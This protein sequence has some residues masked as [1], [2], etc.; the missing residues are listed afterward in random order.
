[1]LVPRDSL[2][3][4]IMQHAE[5]LGTPATSAFRGARDV[6]WYVQHFIARLSEPGDR[7]AALPVLKDLCARIW[8]LDDT[9]GLAALPESLV[10]GLLKAVAQAK[11]WE[12]LEECSSH[13]GGN[14]PEDFFE[15]ASEE[16]ATGRMHMPDVE[17]RYA[18]RTSRS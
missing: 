15:W 4:F 17:K 13:L 2:A 9:K 6:A 11:E 3:D 12:V 10:L 18:R 8:R 16:V 1:M 5:P 7:Q 14:P